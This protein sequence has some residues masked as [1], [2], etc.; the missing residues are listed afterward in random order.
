MYTL[1]IGPKTKLSS[2]LKAMGLI[3]IQELSFIIVT[4]MMQQ[5]LSNVSLSFLISPKTRKMY[6]YPFLIMVFGMTFSTVG[7]HR[8]VVTA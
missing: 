2:T 3:K 5:V 4:A 1:L 8:L 7:S 6:L